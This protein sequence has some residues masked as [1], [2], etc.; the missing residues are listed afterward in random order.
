[1]IWALRRLSENRSNDAHR[2]EPNTSAP[3][4]YVVTTENGSSGCDRYTG[5]DERIV[6]R[7]A[8]PTRCRTLGRKWQNS[9]LSRNMPRVP[10]SGAAP[11]GGP[12][13]VSPEGEDAAH[14]WSTLRA[15]DAHNRGQRGRRTSTSERRGP[16]HKHNRLFGNRELAT[17]TTE[18]ILADELPSPL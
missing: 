15:H 13:F 11:T 9:W 7:V 6:R 1:M 17:L 8:I 4:L 5:R 14:Y 16:R 18:K 10:K 12:R 3:L 2:A